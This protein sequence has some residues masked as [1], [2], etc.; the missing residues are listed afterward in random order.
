MV[1][2]FNGNDI[3]MEFLTSLW[4][5]GFRIDPLHWEGDF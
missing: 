1:P 5:A 4:E 3:F 2:V